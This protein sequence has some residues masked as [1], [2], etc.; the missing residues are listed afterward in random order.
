M[1]TISSA[2]GIVMVFQEDKVRQEERQ[3]LGVEGNWRRGEG[4]PHQVDA[5]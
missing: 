3:G 1:N 5:M 4:R 2:V